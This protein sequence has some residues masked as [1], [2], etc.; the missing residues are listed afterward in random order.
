MAKSTVTELE[1]AAWPIIGTLS[2][3][4]RTELLRNSILHSVAA[5]TVLFE[6]GATPNFQHMLL[7]GS[8]H[9]LGQSGGGEVLIE[10]VGPPDLIVPA[11]VMTGAPYLMT[12][13]APEASRLLLIHAE[14]FRAAITA[15]PNLALQVIDSLAGQYRRMVRQIKNLKLR[16][17]AA[18]AGCYLLALSARQGTPHRALLPYEKTL[19]ASELGMTR[20]SLSRALSSLSAEGVTVRGDTI[21]IR[22]PRGLAVACDFDPLLD[23]PKG[24]PKM[25]K[26]VSPKPARG[27]R[28]ST[29]SGSAR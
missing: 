10:A 20:E 18:R 25:R 16:S 29:D 2:A 14:A 24:L 7:S 17:T 21:T 28:R 5:G 6:Q 9:L 3:S 19:V 13:R 8:V 4:S 22:N 1:L 26:P 23:D 12:A 11:A 15:E 27:S